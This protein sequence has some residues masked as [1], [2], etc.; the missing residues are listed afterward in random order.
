VKLAC[1]V[2]VFLLCS[3]SEGCKR[4][5]ASVSTISTTPTPTPS[6]APPS[7]SPILLTEPETYVVKEGDSIT[8]TCHVDAIVSHK[9]EVS[10]CPCPDLQIVWNKENRTLAEDD[11][12]R[13]V[14][15]TTENG[16]NVTIN[17][18]QDIDAGEYVC[19][20]LDVE[21]RHTVEILV[22]PEVVAVPESGLVTVKEGEPATLA[23]KI[24]RGGPKTYITWS[25]MDYPLFWFSEAHTIPKAEKWTAGV[26]KCKAK[27]DWPEPAFAEIRLD[28]Q[29]AP[30]IQIT[31]H[32]DYTYEWTHLTPI[33]YVEA[34]PEAT[35]EWYKNGQKFEE[36]DVVVKENN[37]MNSRILLRNMGLGH[38]NY[39]DTWVID[40]D[41]IGVYE[42]RAKNYLG[43][44]SAAID[45][46]GSCDRLSKDCFKRV[47]QVNPTTQKTTEELNEI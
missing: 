27:N 46:Y 20:V 47:K 4:K 32:T 13:V 44:A 6:S 2:F 7:Y 10:P 29:H 25:T 22:R 19:K 14:F 23:C 41:R 39:N 31:A 28:V 24:T 9:H 40:Q 16:S 43:E 34:T 35:V 15:E 8:L 1:L 21:I 33:C 3:L 37:S 5:S 30:E 36:D 26:F 45:V 42:C 12:T 38:E 11:D 18:A 17:D